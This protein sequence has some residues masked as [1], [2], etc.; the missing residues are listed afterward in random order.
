[1]AKREKW[2]NSEL[3]SETMRARGRGKEGSHH[4]DVGLGGSSERG[5]LRK[6]GRRVSI[7]CN[8]EKRRTTRN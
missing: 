8:S 3:K 1:M 6:G 7:S 5:E 2:R 4:D